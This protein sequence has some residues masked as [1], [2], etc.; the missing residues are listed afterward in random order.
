[1][2]KFH[3]VHCGQRIEAPAELAGTSANCPACESAIQVP[4]IDAGSVHAAP[5]PVSTPETGTSSTN[6]FEDFFSCSGRIS[7]KT[8]AI[9]FFI[10]LI[11]AIALAF[12]AAW[13]LAFS[14]Y[15]GSVI[16]LVLLLVYIPISSKRLHD[17]NMAGDWLWFPAGFVASQFLMQA[18]VIPAVIKGGA[19][20]GAGLISILG[21]ISILVSLVL[22]SMM[23]FR[24]G[25]APP[26]VVS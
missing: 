11:P 4:A 26:K 18:I 16:W 10:L 8:F 1:M 9:R 14:R 3:C 23:F 2:F 24:Q 6:I 5:I 13:P 12:L 21:V 20:V 17:M 25:S 15:A 19:G 7:R 22:Y